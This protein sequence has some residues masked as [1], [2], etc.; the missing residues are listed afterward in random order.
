MLK[1]FT[2]GFLVN[3]ILKG[4]DV[5]IKRGEFVI[6]LG[7]SGSGKTTL[8]NI[9]SGLDRATEGDVR[10]CDQQ[11]INMSHTKLTEFRKKHIG[12]LCFNNMDYKL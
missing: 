9:M 6:I 10:V 7:P 12:F 8:M 5:D 2:N 11:L 3:E 1:R 4:I